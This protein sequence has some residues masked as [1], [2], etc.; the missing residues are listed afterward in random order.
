MSGRAHQGHRLAFFLTLFEGP[1]LSLRASSDELLPL[2][3]LVLPQLLMQS[4]PDEI[5]TLGGLRTFG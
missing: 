2:S 3:V 5:G 4:A 1:G